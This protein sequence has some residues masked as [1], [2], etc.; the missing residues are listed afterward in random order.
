MVPRPLSCCTATAAS[1]H[2]PV[3]IFLPSFIAGIWKQ[4]LSV[5][6]SL[7]DAQQKKNPPTF[8]PLCSTKLQWFCRFPSVFLLRISDYS[9]R[10][11][12]AQLEWTSTLVAKALPYFREFVTVREIIIILQGQVN[13]VLH[14][15]FSGFTILLL[16]SWIGEAELSAK[17]QKETSLLLSIHSTSLPVITSL[18]DQHGQRSTPA[19]RSLL[20]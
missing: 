19:K 1:F 14:M 12:L 6:M 13:C 8:M 2:L 4:E 10:L 9:S 7:Y 3:P 16:I 20:S 15:L 18:K 5:P 11:A 17:V